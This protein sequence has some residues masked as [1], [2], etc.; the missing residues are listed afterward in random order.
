M[1]VFND[2]FGRGSSLSIVANP[3]FIGADENKCMLFKR[4][5]Q[6]FILNLWGKRWLC[7]RVIAALVVILRGLQA[8]KPLAHASI[9]TSVLIPEWFLDLQDRFKK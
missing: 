5:R 8:K 2:I 9:A 3:I 1:K 4:G 7:P 6:H